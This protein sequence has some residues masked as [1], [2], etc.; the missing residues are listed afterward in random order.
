MPELLQMSLEAN[1]GVVGTSAPFLGVVPDTSKLL[2]PIDGQDYRIEIEGE[3]GSSS[4]KREQL[5]A[6]L[7]VQGHELTDGP[8]THPF[9]EAAQGGLV[10]KPR[11]TQQGEEGPIVLQDLGLVDA[12]QAGDDG[13]HQTQDQIA[14]EILGLTLRDFDVVLKSPAQL[15]FVAKTMQE[16]HSSKVSEVGVPEVETQCSQAPGHG[17]N[18]RGRPSV[19]ISQTYLK[20]SFVKQHSYTQTPSKILSSLAIQQSC[21]RFIEDK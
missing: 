8:R 3:G 20:G 2:F 12:S 19:A 16:D 15:E 1:E 13:V 14:G 10:G 4:G 6:Q 5:S 18:R 11:Q 7:V 21:S 9:E 17:P